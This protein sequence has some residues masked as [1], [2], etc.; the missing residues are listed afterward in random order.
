M[1]FG[2]V[3]K[4]LV[5]SDKLIVS[6]YVLKLTVDALLGPLVMLINCYWFVNK[7]LVDVNRLLAVDLIDRLAEVGVLIDYLGVL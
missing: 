4:L 5:T 3:N 2:Y 1:F 6:R 7:L